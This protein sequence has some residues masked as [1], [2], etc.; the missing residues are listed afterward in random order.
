MNKKMMKSRM[1]NFRK[2]RS[3]DIIDKGKLKERKE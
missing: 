1:K 3:S 2:E